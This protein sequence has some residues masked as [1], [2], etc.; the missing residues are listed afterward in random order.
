MSVTLSPAAPRSSAP[1][2]LP[3][4]VVLLKN[5][6]PPAEIPFFVELSRRVRKLVILLSTPVESNRQWKPEWGS[7]DVR[8]QRTTTLAGRW[9]HRAGFTDRTHFHIPWNTTRLLGQLQPD[10]LVSSELGTRS[11]LSALYRSWRPQTALVVWAALSEHTEL[12]RGLPRRLLRSWLRKRVDHFA[13]NGPSGERYLESLG[14]ER[15]KMSRLHYTILPDV[16][17]AQ[18]VD[19]PVEQAHR[20][21]FVGQL[22]ERKGIVPFLSGLARWCRQHPQRRVDFEIAGSGPEEERI[23][24]V[25][26]PENL[27]VHYLGFASYQDL[28]EY[29]G[30]CGILVYPT[31]ADE[32]GLVVHEGMLTGLPVLGSLFSQAV[33]TLV[34]EGQ[35]GWVYRPDAAG[36]IDAAID[37]AL[38]A[39][40]AELNAMR[41]ASR[42]AVEH[43][44]PAWAADCLVQALRAALA[45]RRGDERWLAAAPADVEDAP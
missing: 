8:V 6:L 13:V 37:R 3:A 1:A 10:V 21:L 18:P 4:K 15:S 26:L 19:R 24:A 20:L 42:A 36:D 22:V 27:H 12:G 38:S 14:V 34:R 30:R 16:F 2:V 35:T 29:Y 9:K 28:P 23:R 11:A 40:T 25:P 32:W 45:R 44:T 43:I 17:D 5:F 7:L 31:L 33:E 39:S 41:A